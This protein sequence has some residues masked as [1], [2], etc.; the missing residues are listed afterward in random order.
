MHFIFCINKISGTPFSIIE[1]LTCFFTM[2]SGNNLNFEKE[3]ITLEMLNESI[4]DLNWLI[5]LLNI[6]RLNI[7][8]SSLEMYIANFS[9]KPQLI[10]CTET[11]LL[12][13]PYM[14][15]ID[16]YKIY[17]NYGKINS[18][19]G[20][21]IY[22]RTDVEHSVKVVDYEG[23]KT[24]ECNVYLSKS[25]HLLVTA[26]YR[27]HDFSKIEFNK[28]IKKILD[29]KEEN[30]LIVGDYNIN[31]LNMDCESEELLNSCY[32][33]GYLP[34]FNTVTRPNE[35]GGSCIDNMYAKSNFELK[36]YKHA[37]V[38][39]DHY[40]LLC[41]I[42]LNSTNN[43]LS[44]H[45]YKVNYNKLLSASVSMDWSA[46][47]VLNDP[48]AMIDLFIEKIQYCIKISTYK[49]KK[50]KLIYRKPWMTS[51]IFESISHKEYL[52]NLWK[53]DKNSR[54]LKTQ[55]KNYEKQLQKIIRAAKADHDVKIA[56]KSVND[57]KKLWKFINTKL[58][59]KKK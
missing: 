6:R 58:G 22:V 36:A 20:V 14:Y 40:P 46:C 45:L 25:K 53:N 33:A 34:L 52:Y 41:G 54:F 5:L 24:L 11:W 27:C 10:V 12:E 28:T 30:H 57:S 9:V 18:A 38:F 21:V 19:D 39:P 7:N 50:K 32:A 17:Y 35:S 31:I 2:A 43:I 23:F 42:D 48:D 1:I 15:E 49:I 4:R 16:N 44:E 59:K 55:Y 8:I 29:N 26:L 51:A 47:T 37:Q 3:C 56:E 13:N